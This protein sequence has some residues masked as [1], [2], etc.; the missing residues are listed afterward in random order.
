M[1]A[2]FIDFI[3]LPIPNFHRLVIATTAD[4]AAL[5]ARICVSGGEKS[6]A[7]SAMGCTAS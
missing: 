3:T 7:S 5:L 2:G 1:M 4:G 6:T